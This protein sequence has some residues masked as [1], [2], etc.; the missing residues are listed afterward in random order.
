MTAIPHP[1]TL[2]RAAGWSRKGRLGLIHTSGATVTPSLGLWSAK[3]AD[4]QKL[5]GIVNRDTAIAWAIGKDVT[6]WTSG[7]VAKAAS[8]AEPQPKGWVSMRGFFRHERGT[9]DTDGHRYYARLVNGLSD[10]FVL[11][12]DAFLWVEGGGTFPAGHVRQERKP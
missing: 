9:V 5:D 12:R 3:R 4:G 6:P 11:K 1:N 2:L 10:K 7:E 8:K